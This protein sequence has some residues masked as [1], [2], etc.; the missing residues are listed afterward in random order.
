[1]DIREHARTRI[2]HPPRR[3]VL[4]E[5]GEKTIQ[6]A[7]LE[8]A[9][10]G[11]VHPVL[12][13]APPELVA[14]LAAERGEPAGEVSPDP[15]S[16]PRLE[17]YAQTYAAAQG[18][19]VGAARLIVGRPLFFAT[20][21]LAHG[22]VDGLVAGI[23]CPTEDVV[24][25]S[26]LCLPGR[27]DAVPCTIYLLDIPGRSGPEGSLLALADP[28]TN[29]RPDADQLAGIATEAAAAVQRMLG[30]QP[31][32]ALLSFSTHGS[33]DDPAVD[34]VRAAADLLRRRDVGFAWDGE[35]Q[36][37]AALD[38]RVAARKLGTDSPVAGRANVLVCPN[39]DA[40][41]IGAK[42]LLH[43]AA[44]TAYGPFLL[45]LDRPVSDLSR[46]AS[47]ADVVGTALLVA[48]ME[49]AKAAGR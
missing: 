16:D 33:A 9:A 25:A 43:F 4:P 5:G 1:M 42:L 22:D 36:L 12:L 49:P 26:R 31:R 44:A 10:T 6:A 48:A 18:L 20:M 15:R 29:P 17:Q 2:E 45:G 28:A 13:G 35:L 37:D 30:W 47:V 11:L 7:A 19:P 21:M 32:V 14:T 38:P 46:G 23:A 24:V 40:A 3:I 41:N 39:L 27:D 8:L 34:V